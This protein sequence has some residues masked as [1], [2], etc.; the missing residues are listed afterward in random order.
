MTPN[1]VSA[2]PAA[3][4]PFEFFEATEEHYERVYGERYE[5]PSLDVTEE[6]STTGD[7]DE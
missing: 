5:G 7:N 2:E 1:S 4:Q 6:D 3:G